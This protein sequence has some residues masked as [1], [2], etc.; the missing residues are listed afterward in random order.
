[1]AWQLSFVVAPAQGA[2]AGSIRRTMRLRDGSIDWFSSSLDWYLACSD[3]RRVVRLWIE[4][5]IFKARLPFLAPLEPSLQTLAR[6]SA[7]FGVLSRRA[8]GKQHTL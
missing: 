7:R 1:M 2:A 4:R 3:E 5:Q 6:L 8:V